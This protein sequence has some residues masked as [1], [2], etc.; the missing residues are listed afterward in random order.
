MMN[1]TNHTWA[2]VGAGPAGLAS[3]G[4]LLDAGVTAKDILWIDPYFQV[5]D[6]GRLWGEVSSNTSVA[7]FLE[8][9]TKIQAFKYEQHPENFALD[10]L[11]KEGFTQLKE[12]AEPL[13]WVTDH[14]R[15]KV[16]AVTGL[17]DTQLARKGAWELTVAGEVYRA[18]KVILATGGS[19]RSLPFDVEEEI[20]LSDALTPEK[21]SGMVQEKD[22]VAVFGSS[23][24]AMIIIK[25]LLDAGASQVVNFYLQPIRYAVP[26]DGW[27]LYDNTGLKG[28]TAAWVR[29]NLSAKTHPKVQR[30]ISN[31][32][33]MDAQLSSCNKVVYATGFSQRA[34]HCEEIDF[35]KYD[36]SCGIIA[37]GLFGTGIGFPKKVTDPNGNQEL[38]VGL[39]K[40]MNDIRHALP[41]WMQYG[42]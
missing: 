13:Q 38:N 27:T 3:V 19:P 31:K 40:F 37:P 23:H 34:P 36:T 41:I 18:E 42:L 12:V 8:F 14:L 15:E 32:E 33:N 20:A 7:L 1:N 35:Q 2:V 17:V 39:W 21:L 5:G 10:N 9:L 25:N 28:K 26:M 4:L 29:E 30:L 24:S 6:F 11:P 22:K 16:T